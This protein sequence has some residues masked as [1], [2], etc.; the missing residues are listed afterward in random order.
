M[1]ALGQQQPLATLSPGRLVSAISGPFMNGWYGSEVEML[2]KER[3]NSATENAQHSMLC[4]FM[5]N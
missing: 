5:L 3:T 2:P 1:S 4:I